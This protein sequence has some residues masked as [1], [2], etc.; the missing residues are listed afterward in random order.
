MAAKDLWGPKNKMYAQ[1]KGKAK[2]IEEKGQRGQAIVARSCHGILPGVPGGLG[3]HVSILVND[4]Y[5]K[6]L[7]K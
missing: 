4:I 1:M 3:C 2:E 6:F 7:I 5:I